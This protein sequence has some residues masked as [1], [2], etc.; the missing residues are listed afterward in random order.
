[1]S[2]RQDGAVRDRSRARRTAQLVTVEQSQRQACLQRSYDRLN[3]GSN[4]AP[5]CKTL[6]KVQD[7]YLPHGYPVP[8]PGC[9][10]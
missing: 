3:T 2:D 1:M 5:W 10:S 4:K 8:F 7:E 6:G 9:V